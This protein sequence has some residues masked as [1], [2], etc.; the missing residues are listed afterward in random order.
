MM[1]GPD[2]LL[3][4]NV[5]VRLSEPGTP[6]NQVALDALAELRRQGANLCIVPQV[7]GEFWSVATNASTANGLGWSAAQAETAVAQWE[8]LFTLLPET[9]DIYSEWKRIVTTGSITGRRAHDARL[10]AAMKVHG[11]THILTF[12]PDDFRNIP[13]ITIIEPSTLLTP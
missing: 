6:L 8:A 5:V 11:L 2:Y 13:D 4:T 9:D 12:N 10:A 3:D 7:I 1:N